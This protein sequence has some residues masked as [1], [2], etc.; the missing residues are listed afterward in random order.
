VIL[1]L[2]VISLL[3][4]TVVATLYRGIADAGMSIHMIGEVS[5]EPKRRRINS[6][7]M[8]FKHFYLESEG[9]GGLVTGVRECNLK[10]KKV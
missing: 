3:L 4:T 7:M 2:P 8:G 1:L 10:A 9:Y 5:W 6:S